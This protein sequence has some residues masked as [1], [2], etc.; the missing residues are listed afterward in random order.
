VWRIKD[1]GTSATD[2]WGAG[3]PTMTAASFPLVV[4]SAGKVYAA[5]CSGAS[6]SSG[7]QAKLYQLDAT[8]GT[9]EQCRVLGTNIT[10]GDPALDTVLERLIVGA[11][12][13][14]LH[15]YSAPGGFLGGDPS[16]TP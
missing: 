3:A 15:A 8:T 4:P 11:S 10:P 1:N 7:S 2:L 9:K 6:C 16:C 12:D 13:G 14:K 5:G